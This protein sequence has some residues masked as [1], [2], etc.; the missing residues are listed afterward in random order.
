MTFHA[1]SPRTSPFGDPIISLFSPLQSY[2]IIVNRVR[3]GSQEPTIWV[4]LH[5]LWNSLVR[6]QSAEIDSDSW[7]GPLVLSVARFT[8]NLIADVPNNQNNAL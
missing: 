1:N 3:H 5:E 8:R 6:T 4:P 7:H 2:L